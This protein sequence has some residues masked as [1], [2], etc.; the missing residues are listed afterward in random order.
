[1]WCTSLSNIFFIF[2]AVP[3]VFANF[4]L[5][6]SQYF[7]LLSKDVNG[8]FIIHRGESELMSH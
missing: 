6:F 4:F 1:M 7:N 5:T 3:L 2:F 8:S